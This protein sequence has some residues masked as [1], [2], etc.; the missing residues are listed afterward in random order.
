MVKSVYMLMHREVGVVFVGATPAALDA[1]LKGRDID[2]DADGEREHGYYT[3]E[4]YVGES[5]DPQYYR[6]DPTLP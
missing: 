3:D 4:F 1:Y 2:L 5:T 6:D